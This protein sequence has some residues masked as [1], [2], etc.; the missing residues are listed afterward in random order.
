MV[1]A[2]L[3]WASITGLLLIAWSLFTIPESVSQ[4]LFILGKRSDYELESLVT[5]FLIGT[6]AAGRL[7]G[8]FLTGSI[9][10]FQGWRLDPILQF[11]QC[12]LVIGVIFESASNILRDRRNWAA[13]ILKNA[14]EKYNE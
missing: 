10:F 11:G 7:L 6:R 2:S 14:Q 8:C 3:N 4:L 12:I 9:L 13:K 5:R 1:N